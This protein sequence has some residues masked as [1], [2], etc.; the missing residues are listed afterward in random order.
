[1]LFL[2]VKKLLNYEGKKGGVD[3]D[4]DDGMKNKRG[5]K[6][7]RRGHEGGGEEEEKGFRI[8]RQS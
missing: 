1:M 7:S 5:I 2:D 8:L 6:R 3:E 4:A